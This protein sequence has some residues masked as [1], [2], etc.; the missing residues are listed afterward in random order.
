MN[1]IQDSV[2]RASDR[3][4]ALSDRHDAFGELVMRFQNM[5]FAYSFAVLGDAYLAEDVAQEAFITAWH[6]LAQLREPDAFPGWFKRILA[7][8]CNRLLRSKRLQFVPTESAFHIEVTDP[9]PDQS[10]ERR[11]LVSKVLK[12]IREL[13]E[14]QRL[15]TMLFYVD[16]YTQDEIGRFLDV[17]IST[18]NKRLHTAREKLK[19]RMVE[20]VKSDLEQKRPSRNNDFS[21]EVTARLRPL[22]ENDWSSITRLAF[23]GRPRD[24]A[25][26]ELWLTQRQNFPESRYQRRQ[27][28][29]EDPTRKLIIGYGAIEQSMYLPR[30]KLFLVASPSWLRKG[31]GDLL[32]DQLFKDLLD[33]KAVTV[34]CHEHAS[35]TEL[36]G[37]LL[38][39]G[40]VEVDRQLDLRLN[41]ADVSTDLPDG[42][43][44]EKI[45]I[46]IS[47]LS[48]ERATDPDYVKKLYRLSVM[49]AEE[50]ADLRFKP[51]A[52][53]AREAL[54]WLEMPHVL[55]DGYFIAKHDDRYVAV[56]DVNLRDCLPHGVTLNG[57]GVL[58]Q[59]RRRGIASALI[60][61][62][63]TYAKTSGYAVIRA[64]NQ[65]SDT[66]LLHLTR[67]MGFKTEF[68][69]ITLEKLLRPVIKITNQN[70]YDDYSGGYVVEGPQGPVNIEVRRENEHLT[71]ECIGQKVELFP[72]SETKFFIK[73]FY[74]EINFGRS[75]EGSVSHLDY[76]YDDGKRFENY[77]ATKIFDIKN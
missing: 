35:K 40:F 27:Y 33:A 57:P 76:F 53:D 15:V 58:A 5:A 67:R 22:T 20:V 28:V 66:S 73:M 63:L 6:K 7:T 24:V 68:E 59:Y 49:L 29:A 32:L 1:S 52:Y 9:G 34:S 69:I 64:F 12:A 75:A 30:Y 72:T 48:N 3:S 71:L 47:T 4:V 51:P 36:I 46:T 23:G 50:N 44:L 61:R 25:G 38:K 42:K 21:N 26:K 54:M 39:R 8:Q 60:S 10:A 43:E 11:Q 18:V 17:P 77:T 14:K 13:P 55:P 56:V 16:G 19:E 62:A 45:G 74:G 65:P 37:L 41:L 31:V 70:L 2:I